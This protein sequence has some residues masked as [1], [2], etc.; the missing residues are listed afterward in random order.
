M[1]FFRYVR[2]LSCMLFTLHPHIPLPQGIALRAC[3]L[4]GGIVARFSSIS[5]P[6]PGRPRLPGMGVVSP[7]GMRTYASRGTFDRLQRRGVRN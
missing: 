4:D 1:N 6:L 7:V 3:L 5:R 2:E